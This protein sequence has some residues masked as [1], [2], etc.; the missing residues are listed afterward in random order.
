MSCL[1]DDTISAHPEQSEQELQVIM[2]DTSFDAS[3]M[4]IDSLGF[5]QSKANE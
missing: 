5:G 1:V 3:E 2:T 4:Y